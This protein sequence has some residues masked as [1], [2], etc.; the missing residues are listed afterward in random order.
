M[1]NGSL[2]YNINIMES[3]K[4]ILIVDDE[5]QIARAYRDHFDRGGYDVDVAYDGEE[6]LT[7]IKD[8]APDIILLDILMPRMDGLSTLKE[9]KEDP[10]F[11]HIPVIMLTNLDQKEDM[12]KASE[13][14]VF[15]YFIKANTSLEVLDRW[16]K[17]LVEDK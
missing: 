14:G 17:D 13:S 9:L 1:R 10:D 8:S 4:K 15:L 2:D 12:V 7:K 5:V 3:K 11:K 6:A 16:V